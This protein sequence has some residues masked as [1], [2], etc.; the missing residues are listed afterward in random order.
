M[1]LGIRFMAKGEGAIKSTL[2]FFFPDFE[3]QLEQMKIRT[4]DEAKLMLDFLTKQQAETLKNQ[5]ERLSDFKKKSMSYIKDKGIQLCK[6]E[7][8]PFYGVINYGLSGNPQGDLNLLVTL[9]VASPN[10]EPI[11]DD[12][13][14]IELAKQV[15]TRYGQPFVNFHTIDLNLPLGYN[16]PKLS[17]THRHH[18]I[19]SLSQKDLVFLAMN[20]SPSYF[21]D[22]ITEDYVEKARERCYEEGLLDKEEIEYLISER[23]FLLSGASYGYSTCRK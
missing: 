5:E 11:G 21:L 22:F 18:F 10:L 15:I 3:H 2:I 23:M 14:K 1:L 4:F 8:E 12:E 19:Q 6:L 20:L 7:D 13:F 9:F 16:N 17:A